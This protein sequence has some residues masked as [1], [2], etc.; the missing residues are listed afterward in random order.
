LLFS[1][2]RLPPYIHLLISRSPLG[3]PFSPSA[4]IYFLL[5]VW[6]VSFPPRDSPPPLRIFPDFS[7][8]L[9]VRATQLS[10]F[11]CLLLG[12]LCL[13]R[14]T[15]S[16]HAFILHPLEGWSVSMSRRLSLH[17]RFLEGF[18]LFPPAFFRPETS[19]P[20]V[21]PFVLPA[22]Y[23]LTTIPLS[24]QMRRLLSPLLADLIFQCPSLKDALNP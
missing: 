17:L 3:P 5:S 1:E 14:C 19:S 4:Q 9:L 22:T 24:W 6:F 2:F 23:S 13:C 12:V 10:S 20:P 21:R 11:S 7:F 8:F 18:L 15:I 16:L